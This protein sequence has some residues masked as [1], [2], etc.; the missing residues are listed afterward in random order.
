[1]YI[2]NHENER[3][4]DSQA[5]NVKSMWN[6]YEICQQYALYSVWVLLFTFDTKRLRNDFFPYFPT[7][8]VRMR[9][10]ESFYVIV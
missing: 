4:R 9:Y 10:T 3:E 5:P 7:Y 8:I 1:M 2:F 6:V